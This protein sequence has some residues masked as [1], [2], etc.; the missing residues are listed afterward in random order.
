MSDRRVSKSFVGF[1]AACALAGCAADATSSGDELD[2]ESGEIADKDADPS[3]ND[4]GV[5][6]QALGGF[7]HLLPRRGTR[8]DVVESRFLGSGMMYSMQLRT[9]A[10]V[11]AV[12]ASFYTPSLPNNRY[13]DGDPFFARGPVGGTAGSAQPRLEC[14]PVFAA[15]GLYG[16]AGNRVDQLGLV[17]AQIGVDG[18]PVLSTQRV[19]GAFGGAGGTAFFDTCGAGKW[20]TGIAVDVALKSSGTNK[21]ISAVQGSCSNGV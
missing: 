18:L 12:S 1:F 3:Q 13:S 15:T 17:C 4:L 9:G 8:N 21:I 11:D 16:R 2:P 20:L 7:S 14:P 6:S 19:V 10:L 5:D